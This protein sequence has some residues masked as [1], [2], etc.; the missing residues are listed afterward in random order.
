MDLRVQLVMN[1]YNDDEDE[2]ED[3]D[4]DDDDDEKQYQFDQSSIYV[5]GISH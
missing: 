4:D 3:D 2:N 5:R 1:I